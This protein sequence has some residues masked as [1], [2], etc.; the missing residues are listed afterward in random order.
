[1]LVDE[2]LELLDEQE[3]LNLMATAR[4]GRVA[5]TV[6]ALPAIFPVNFTL[7][8]QCIIFR[9]G[10][11]TKLAAATERTVV[12]FECD[13]IDPFE[14]RGWSVMAVGRAERV[15]DPTEL[16]HVGRLPVTPWAGGR[17]SS[18]V[19]IRIEFVSGRRI[20][21]DGQPTEQGGGA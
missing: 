9:T 1:M 15:D 11:G 2:G 20:L 16:A 4:I 6:G 12:A 13:A 19:R 3:C 17:R 7:D 5:V 8:R 18:L 14:H 10:E 21:V